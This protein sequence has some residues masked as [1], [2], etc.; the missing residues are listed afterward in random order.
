MKTKKIQKP[1]SPETWKNGAKVETRDGR[2]AR[3]LCTDMKSSYPIVAIVMCKD[4]KEFVTEYDADGHFYTGT[5]HSSDLVITEEVEEEIEVRYGDHVW[6]DGE[7]W[8]VESNRIIHDNW[9]TLRS[10]V[11][12]E[13][14]CDVRRKGLIRCD[15]FDPTLFR[16]FHRVLV[17]EHKE[18]GNYC[19]R[20]FAG[21]FS[22]IKNGKYFTD[23]FGYEECIPYNLETMHLVGTTDDAPEFYVTEGSS[24]TV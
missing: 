20:W 12:N 1:F 17:R 15:R 8:I 5:I 21:Y 6:Y 13:E 4:G 22:H 11:S 3:I 7:Q 19:N 10:V 23:G 18:F 9:I 14:L 2:A 16:P 24:D